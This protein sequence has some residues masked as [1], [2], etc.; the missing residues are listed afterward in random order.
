MKPSEKKIIKEAAQIIAKTIVKKVMQF[1]RLLWRDKQY[2][3][4]KIIGLALFAWSMYELLYGSLRTVPEEVEVY[5]ASLAMGAVAL[6]TPSC[7]MQ[8][9]L[10]DK[11][12]RRKK[13]S[14]EEKEEED[15]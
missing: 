7:V 13:R 6:L 15:V 2:V 5:S 12:R 1:P 8:D 3:A 9:L 11:P 4:I 10:S 14:E